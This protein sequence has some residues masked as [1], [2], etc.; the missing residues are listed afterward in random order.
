LEEALVQSKYTGVQPSFDRKED[1]P[2]RAAHEGFPGETMKEWPLS[3]FSPNG[4]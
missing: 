4:T 1:M 2:K 3:T